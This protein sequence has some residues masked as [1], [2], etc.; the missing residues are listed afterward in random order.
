MVQRRD[1]VLDGDGNAKQRGGFGVRHEAGARFG[2][3]AQVFF[4][5]GNEYVESLTSRLDF[6]R[7]SERGR[8]CVLRREDT[9]VGV[10][11]Q[12]TRSVDGAAH[13]SSA[14]SCV[15]RRGTRMNPSRT[16]GATASSERDSGS[17]G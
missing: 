3:L 16:F 4:V 13:A 1:V 9:A 2:V 12:R 10:L 7:A 14:A 11:A 6:V 8:H 17:G 5:E 15:D